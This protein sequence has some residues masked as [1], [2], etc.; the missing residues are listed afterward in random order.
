MWNAVVYTRGNFSLFPWLSFPLYNDNRLHQG[1]KLCEIISAVSNI[2]SSSQTH[3][4][5]FRG[6]VL[7]VCVIGR[8]C[9]VVMSTVSNLVW[10]ISTWFRENISLYSLHYLSRACWVSGLW[11]VWSTLLLV[12]V[13]TSAGQHTNLVLGGV[14]GNVSLGCFTTSWCISRFCFS[15]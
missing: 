1:E 2:Y 10:T 11:G 8:W 4:V 6:R 14:Q 13:L 12:C 9:S 5:C 7:G 15:W 3:W